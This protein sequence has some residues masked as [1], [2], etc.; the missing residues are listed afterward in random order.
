MIIW[1]SVEL[2]GRAKIWGSH[3]Q[4]GYWTSFFSGEH[5]L[6]TNINLNFPFPGFTL[7]E[8]NQK[9]IFYVISWV[10]SLLRGG[11]W[12]I[13]R[14][15]AKILYLTVKVYSDTPLLGKYCHVIIICGLYF[16]INRAEMHFL[17]VLTWIWLCFSAGVRRGRL[18]S[19]ISELWK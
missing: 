3:P 4:F 8:N 14:A 11:M 13:M 10:F 7:L 6:N 16:A 19:M 2:G 1:L 18:C 9:R 17:R 15:S 5:V 12:G